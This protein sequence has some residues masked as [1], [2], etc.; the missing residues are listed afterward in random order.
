MQINVD[1]LTVKQIK[2]ITGLLK[3]GTSSEVA[4]PYTIGSPYF[5]RLVTHFLTGRVIK[6]TSKEIVLTE[7]AWI[8]DTG[9][10]TQAIA[11]GKLNEVEPY[12]AD[13]EV[14]IGRG[15]LID[16]VKWKHELPKVQK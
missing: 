2:Q 1:E 4:H 3:G 14:I 11:D 9:R 12:P 13:E 15:A 6:V 10:F 7:A 16:C 5:F 8:A